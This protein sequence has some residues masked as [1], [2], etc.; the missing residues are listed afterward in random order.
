MTIASRSSVRPP[1]RVSLLTDGL[2]LRP[3]IFHFLPIVTGL[4]SFQPLFVPRVCQYEHDDNRRE[5]ENIHSTPLYYSPLIFYLPP[6]PLLACRL[7]KIYPGTR[8]DL[9]FG[10][11]G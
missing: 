11:L 7:R 2:E 3:P 8:N 5:Y 4:A 9:F 6:Y 1:E 10:R